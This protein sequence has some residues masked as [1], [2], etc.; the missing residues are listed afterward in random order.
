MKTKKQSA[1]KTTVTVR[2]SPAHRERLRKLAAKKG[3]TASAQIQTAVAAYL[4]S[5]GV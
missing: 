4:D 2:L 1:L 5:E 3:T